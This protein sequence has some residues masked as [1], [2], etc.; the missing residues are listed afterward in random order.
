VVPADGAAGAVELGVARVHLGR[1]FV[2]RRAEAHLAAPF[3]LGVVPG[4]HEPL[5]AAVPRGRDFAGE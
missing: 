2:G 5:E 4:T 1:H 3:F